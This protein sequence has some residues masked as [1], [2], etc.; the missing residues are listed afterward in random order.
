MQTQSRTIPTFDLKLD[1]ILDG[2]FPRESLNIL[3]GGPGAG[4]SIFAHHLLFHYLQVHPASTVLY[5]T[6]LSEPPAKLIRYMRE[7]S[8]FKTEQFQSQFQLEDIGQVVRDGDL[9]AIGEA[10]Q[11]HVQQSAPDLLVI[12]SF[13]AIRDLTDQLDAFR[14][15]V[16]QTAV[17]LYSERCTTFFVGEYPVDQV[18][19]GAEFAVADGIV[20]FAHREEDGEEQRFLQIRKMRGANPMTKPISFSIDSS[21][22]AINYLPPVDLSES[23]ETDETP[24]ERLS[25][26]IDGL[27]ELTR[28]GLV[29]GRAILL[30]GVSGTGKTTLA[31]QLAHQTVQ[32]GH[33]ALY[34]SFEE[35]VEDLL[36]TAD[37]F[38]LDLD[39]YIEQGRLHF[40]YIP[41]NSIR[42][43]EQ[44]R[45]M[46]E[47]MEQVNPD[48][49]V[50]DSFS[51]FLYRVTEPARFREW[52]FQLKALLVRNNAVGILISDI[53]VD[54][55]ERLSR[56]GVEETVADGTIV[57][58][59]LMEETT[60][61][62]Y[63]EVYKM[64][65]TKH[66]AG[67][68]RM[69]ITDDGIQVYYTNPDEHGEGAVVT[70]FS[71]TP[72]QS[73]LRED[74]RYDS[75]WLIRGEPGLGKSTLALQFAAEGVENDES[76]IF[77]TADTPSREVRSRLTDMEIDVSAM[78]Q[79]GR[80][81]I[82]DAYSGTDPGAELSDIDRFLYTLET[83]AEAMNKPVRVIFDSITPL[84]TVRT[85]RHLM[86]LIQRKNRLLRTPQITLLDTHLWQKSS[87]NQPLGLL[88]EYDIVIDLYTTG[89]T[90]GALTRE[91][92]IK[93]ARG[94]RADMTPH[95][96]TIDSGEGILVE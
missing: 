72:V 45:Q 36:F 49:V 3:A 17:R 88:N 55:P 7:F 64:R 95:T 54:A 81:E 47:E 26:G 90:T 27:D 77:I 58:S 37:S 62:R 71:F 29:P 23:S 48:L 1:S 79:E 50:I 60:R 70:P 86:K 9:T 57:L 44:V 73:L 30:S 61:R 18:T 38:G 25:T 68:H 21:G 82:L 16:Y 34:Y 83:T 51:V 85:A 91:L 52:M 75:A 92:Q 5:L 94:V 93:K 14:K 40:Q 8:F 4:K 89:E 12:D 35:P 41:Q 19:E 10:I 46:Q 11:K 13:K 24:N 43:A 22:I 65:R 42:V 78:Q 76:I 32:D 96:Y 87:E 74:L 53:P 66:I 63:I 20:T 33:K 59:S 28:G 56:V 69:A 84:V 80:L 67:R 2:G 6:T 15:F 31:L 39:P